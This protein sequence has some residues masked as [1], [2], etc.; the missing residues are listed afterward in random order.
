MG[1]KSFPLPPGMSEIMDAM[2]VWGQSQSFT[3]Y[4][5]VV[6]LMATCLERQVF[7]LRK[8]LI[9]E[10][11]GI[12]VNSRIGQ[13]DT[14]STYLLVDQWKQWYNDQWNTSGDKNFYVLAWSAFEY[15]DSVIKEHRL[16]ASI[17]A[18]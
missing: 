1:G 18:S 3:W 5:A 15:I 9:R 11:I 14:L 16:S 17:S 4:Q 7:T 2:Y 8:D 6:Q 13:E 10:I 12:E